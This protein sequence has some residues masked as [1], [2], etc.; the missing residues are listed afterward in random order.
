MSKK[1]HTLC[2]RVM[3]AEETQQQSDH[4]FHC[5][6]SSTRLKQKPPM[7]DEQDHIDL[8]LSPSFLPSKHLDPE[9]S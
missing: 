4:N 9:Q 6:G 1:S 7:H 3:D 8:V 2:S 5:V